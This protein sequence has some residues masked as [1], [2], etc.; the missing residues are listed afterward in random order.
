MNNDRKETVAQIAIALMAA[1]GAILLAMKCT[2]T[3]RSYEYL[4]IGVSDQAA[5]SWDIIHPDRGICIDAGV[6]YRCVATTGAM[7]RRSD[8][9]IITVQCAK[10]T[11]TQKI[12]DRITR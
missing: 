9:A 10:P 3:E 11:T 6:Q 5:C 1:L 4:Y 12:I 2:P 7:T 8:P